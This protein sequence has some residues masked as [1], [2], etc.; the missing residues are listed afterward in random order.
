MDISKEL[1]IGVGLAILFLGIVGILL[2]NN[3]QPA[4]KTNPTLSPVSTNTQTSVSKAYSI[5][6]VAKHAVESDCWIVINNNVYDATN[7]LL[8]HPGGASAIT[9][10]CGGDA[11][12]AYEGMRKHSSGRAVADLASI[13]IGTIK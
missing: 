6:E 7:Y 9:P 4:T 2:V 8:V 12:T 13:I 11:T 10:Y 1:K 3:I 5:S